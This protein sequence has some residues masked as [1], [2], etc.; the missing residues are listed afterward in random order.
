MPFEKLCFLEDTS[1]AAVHNFTYA[2]CLDCVARTP[3]CITRGPR[4]CTHSWIGYTAL[5][6]IE[7]ATVR[8]RGWPSRTVEIFPTALLSAETVS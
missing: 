4:T 2:P 6:I 7:L 8:A 1:S 3:F 5:K